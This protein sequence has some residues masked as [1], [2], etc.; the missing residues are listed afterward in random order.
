MWVDGYWKCPL[1]DGY[2]PSY[3]N[4][5]KFQF[6]WEKDLPPIRKETHENAVP[7]LPHAESVTPPLHHP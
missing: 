5:G 6:P 1:Q 7:K 3:F 4:E 2:P